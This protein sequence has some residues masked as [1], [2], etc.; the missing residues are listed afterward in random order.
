MLHKR[1][2]RLAADVVFDALGVGVRDRG[3]HAQRL[4]EFDD[5]LVAVA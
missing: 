2:Q 3:G 1:M 5:H 4:Q